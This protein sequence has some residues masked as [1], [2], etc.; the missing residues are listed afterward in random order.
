MDF[1]RKLEVRKCSLLYKGNN[2]SIKKLVVR[3]L[4][5]NNIQQIVIKNG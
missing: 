4:Y 5:L 1:I 3:R 2:L